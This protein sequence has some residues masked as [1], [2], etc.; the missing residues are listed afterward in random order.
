MLELL[1]VHEEIYL[2]LLELRKNDTNLKYSFR[3]SNHANR[4]E[5]GYWFY[6]N[7]DYFAISFWNGMD[8]KNRTPNIVFIITRNGRCYLEVNVSDSDLKKEFVDRF[9][10]N[11]L[12]LIPNGRKFIKMYSDNS[13]YYLD[14]F[15]LFLFE[16]KKKIDLIISA[17]SSDFFRDKIKDNAIKMIS[18]DEFNKRH[19][20]IKLYR[21]RKF[22]LEEEDDFYLNEEKPSKILSMKLKSFG[23]ISDIEISIES[24]KN[25]WIFITG[26]NGSGKSNLLRSIATVIGHRLLSKKELI[27][28][29]N[30]SAQFK[31]LFKNEVTEFDRVANSNARG[32][33]R[34]LMQGLAMYGP[35]RLDTTM[36]R[37][38]KT[39]FYKGL[40]KE[41]MFK[42]LFY[43]GNELLS[44]D[45]QFELWKK[46]TKKEKALLEKRMYFFNSVLAD[47]VPNLLRIN[48]KEELTNLPTEYVFLDTETEKSYCVGWDQL[49]SGTKS[50]IALIGDILIRFYD[51]QRHIN[52]PSEFRGVVLIDEID[53]HLHPQGQKD[54]VVN[55]TKTFPNIQFI[56]TTHSPIPLLGANE[57]SVF[58]R[59]NRKYRTII[60]QRLAHIEKYIGELLPNQLLTS[61]LFGLDSIISI[62]NKKENKESI[63][64]G[65]TFTEFVNYKTLIESNLLKDPNNDDFIDRFLKKLDEKGK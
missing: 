16:D 13:N 40:N 62:R 48:F 11:Q 24:K 25:Q 20:K 50:T 64:T 8:W 12:E 39:N 51:Q 43:S 54:L 29:P 5:E 46:G 21:T 42:S 22:E 47:I 32:K 19:H 1:N 23:L 58:Y 7:E 33:R 10:I 37:I 45:K 36:D 14:V 28:N 52:D 4:L 53:L 60:L 63:F 49:S 34:P 6:G 61:D 57:N 41:G 30:F 2:F 3:K 31:L 27:E 17:H 38:S 59:V 65:S 18:S 44:I 35:Y 56:V 15:K 55:L 26:E 9:I